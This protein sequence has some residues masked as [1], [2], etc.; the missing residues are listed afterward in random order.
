[1]STAIEAL[2]KLNAHARAADYGSTARIIPQSAIYA[3]KKQALYV[4]S[5]AGVATHRRVFYRAKC[6]NCGDSGWHRRD[7]GCY[8]CGGSGLNPGKGYKDLCFVESTLPGG[9]VWHSPDLN[10]LELWHAA[11][12][13]TGEEAAPCGDWRPLL[14]GLPI[15]AAEAVGM[16][17]EV[18]TWLRPTMLVQAPY[19]L[20]LRKEDERWRLPE[21]ATW[22]RRHPEQRGSQ[23]WISDNDIP[24]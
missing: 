24:F 17:N 3:L 12:K 21:L 7:E 10:V 20:T 6:R 8:T 9:I 14:P 23:W 13:A 4:L 11:G 19:C 15:D 16:L 5:A 18:E 22:L 2:D 1:M